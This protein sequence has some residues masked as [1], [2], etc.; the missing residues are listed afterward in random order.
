MKKTTL[1]CFAAVLISV[2]ALSQN[3]SNS[4]TLSPYSQYGF[5][6]LA[7]QSQGFNRGMNGTGIGMRGGTLINTLNPASYSAV[8]SL[9]MLFDAGLSAQLTNFKEN[10]TSVN[11][12]SADVDY[13]AGLFRVMP[14]LGVSFG[15]LPFSD[16]GYSYTTATYINNTVGSIA[17][18]YSGS[19]GMHQAFVGVGW[20]PVK[21][22]SIGANFAYL[23]GKY[24]RSIVSSS[25]S[26]NVTSINTLSKSYKA[27]I[28][29]YTL[30]LGAQ[31]QQSLG[32]KDNVTLGATFGLGH[33]LGADPTCEIVNINTSTLV[34]DT[35]T[36]TI[37]NGLKLPSSYG[38]GLSWSHD[39]RLT[40][41]ADYTLQKWGDT[42][43]PE[44][45][46]NTKSYSLRSG[47]LCDRTRLSLGA[48]YVHNS[49]S[50]RYLHRVHFRL[51]AALATPYYKVNGHDGP[52]E[53]SLSI[54]LGLPLQNKWNNRSVLN[55]SAQWVRTAATDLITD[56]TFRISVGLTFN[57][58]WFAKWRIE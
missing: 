2:T 46:D 5:G 24:D 12:S 6:V 57:E 15:V 39:E 56:N 55:V 44:Y 33:K 36:F 20:S 53:T 30:T 42:D 41:A 50:V 47:L 14:R 37:S 23:W 45:D 28:S 27:S 8:D 29:N 17:E 26:S 16:I 22:L 43:Y 19:G 49:N 7:D 21:S 13:V 54:G 35:T 51:G 9:T 38:V 40:V 32:R 34:A 3:S 52:K 31:W 10:G 48:D 11:A 4:S 25:G 1:C 58:R 18:S